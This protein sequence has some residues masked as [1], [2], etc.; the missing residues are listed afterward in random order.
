MAS[1]TTVGLQPTPGSLLQGREERSSLSTMQEAPGKADPSL[2]LL[3]SGGTSEE[4][5]DLLGLKGHIQETGCF[6]DEMKQLS[7]QSFLTG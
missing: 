2:S 3:L 4:A 1:W 5:S 6:R 7:G